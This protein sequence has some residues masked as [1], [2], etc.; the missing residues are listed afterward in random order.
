MLS[1]ACGHTEIEHAQMKIILSCETLKQS[2]RKHGRLCILNVAPELVD[3]G[4]R[5]YQFI[6]GQDSDLLKLK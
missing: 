4:A 2:F 3:F 5:V 6:D 1:H